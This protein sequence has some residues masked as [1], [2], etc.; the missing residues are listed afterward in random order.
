MPAGEN[1]TMRDKEEVD[2]LLRKVLLSLAAVEALV[3]GFFVA[4]KLHLFGN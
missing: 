2:P 4:T 3:I 1:E